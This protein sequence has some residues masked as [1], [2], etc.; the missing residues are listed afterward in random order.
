VLALVLALVAGVLVRVVTG[1]VAVSSLLCVD[2]HD[3]C[4]WSTYRV[5]ND[6]S[7]PVVLREWDNHCGR[8]DHRSGLIT[9]VPELMTRDD[10]I[11][12]PIGTRGWWEVATASGTP[13]GCL[14]LDGHP[15]KQ[16]GDVV[17]I[18]A[19]RPCSPREPTTHFTVP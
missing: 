8:G 17:A 2:I 9:V 19:A 15:A 18:S 1:K 12:E 16:D 4:N 14:V 6:T 7:A 5:L 13:L 3:S 11:V 10:A